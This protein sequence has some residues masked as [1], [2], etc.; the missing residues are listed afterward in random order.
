VFITDSYMGCIQAFSASG[1][2]VGVV[3]AN[4]TQRKFTTP[5]GLA[6]DAQNRLLVVEMRANRVSIVK[7]G[8]SP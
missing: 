6:F 4:G 3:C 8:P 2:F 5:V 1:G 7:V